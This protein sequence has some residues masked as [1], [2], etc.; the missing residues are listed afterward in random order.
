M[1]SYIFL[2][3]TITIVTMTNRDCLKKPASSLF[4]CG[5][6]SPSFY[7]SLI[8]CMGNSWISPTHFLTF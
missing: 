7:L 2:A 3:Y 4:S 5:K 8:Y 1:F 6:E